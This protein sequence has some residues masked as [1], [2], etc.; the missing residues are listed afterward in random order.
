MNESFWRSLERFSKRIKHCIG[1]KYSEQQRSYNNPSY[2]SF[3]EWGNH[4]KKH[5]LRKIEN[6]Y[7]LACYN[8]IK[9]GGK[10]G[11]ANA[12]ED[13]TSWQ[14][15]FDASKKLSPTDKYQPHHRWNEQQ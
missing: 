8:G 15:F 7:C 4:I 6:Y 3:L 11:H 12:L 14:E 1:I 2:S 10:V 13:K 9:L 5:K